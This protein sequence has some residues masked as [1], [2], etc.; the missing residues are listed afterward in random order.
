[1][2]SYAYKTVNELLDKTFESYRNLPAYTSLGYTASFADIDEHSRRFASYLQNHTGLKP[3]DRI[4][5]QLPNILQYPV[6]MYGA[7]RAGLILVNTNPLYTPAELVHQLSDSGAKALVVLANVAD[8]AAEIIARTQVETVIVT[9]VGDM[10]PPVKR[11]LVNFVLRR[12]KKAVPKFHFD[13]AIS[14]REAM[15]QGDKPW[16]PVEVKP[17]DTFVLQYTGGT[18]GVAKGAML[19]HANL[20]ANVTQVLHHMHKLFKTESQVAV[21]ALPLYHIFAFNLHALAAFSRGAH[22]VLIPNPR[23]IPALVK[24]I[25][26]YKVSVF[27]AV[28]TLYNAMARSPEFAKLDFSELKT[29]AAGG[30]AVT[31]DVTKRWEQITG[32]KLCEGYGLT[33]TSPVVLTNP[34]DAIELGTI[35]TVLLD[36]EAQIVDENDAP[37]GDDTPG[38]LW[39]RGPQVMAGYWQ[40]PEETAAAMTEDGWFK[41][42]DI[43]VR[44]P[45]GYHK[46]VDR[47]K[48]M[49]L[50]SGFNVYPN[51]VEDVATQHPAIIEAAA[52]GVPSEE[53]GEA[54][55]LFIVT[56][57]KSLTAEEVIKHCRKSLT[58]YKVPKF[59]E[60]KDE[61]PKTNVG[62]IL[63]RA[64][65]D[66]QD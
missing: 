22:N 11:H 53:T 15:A 63:R 57:D 21:A 31:A 61:L 7:V 58:N 4:A 60:F 36:T 9:E 16:Q 43:A 56:D 19:T 30:M 47:K 25:K 35:G 65:R 28:N 59:V 48:D 13:K 42:G 38:E 51:E 62:K 12:I 14:F 29:C 49:V 52:I 41:T 2:D 50:V 44:K 66:T 54:V 27:I 1:M 6:V 3:G 18:T 5:I 10:L 40:R 45:N 23:D 46:I 24:A 33:E 8:R 32:N 55:K 17:E 34:D 64:L 26:G 39:V 37:V 20:C